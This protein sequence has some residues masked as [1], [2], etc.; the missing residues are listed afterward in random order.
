MKKTLQIVG[1]IL[2]IIGM[3]YLVLNFVIKGKVKAALDKEAHRGKLNY[4][5]L[6]Y[7]VFNNTFRVDSLNLYPRHDTIR[8]AHIAV[9]GLGYWAYLTKNTIKLGKISIDRPTIQIQKSSNAQNSGKH[10]LSKIAADK[11]LVVG[12]LKISGGTFTLMKDTLKQLQLDD[13]NVSLER[14]ETSSKTLEKKIP[15]TYQDYAIQGGALYYHASLLQTLKVDSLNLTKDE[16]VFRHLQ[17][18]PNYS[19]QDYIKVIPYEKDLMKINLQRLK[20]H[21]YQFEFEGKHPRFETSLVLLDSI[22]VNIYRN[23]LVK[24]DPREKKMYSR[25]IRELPLKL[26]I[27]SLQVIGADLSY[28]EVQEKTE[29]TGKVFFKDMDIVGTDITNIHLEREDFPVTKLNIAT[30]FYGVAPLN[31]QW[32]FKTNQLSDEFRIQGESHHI[33]AD[34]V[35]LFFE[36]GMNLKAKGE[37]IQGLYFDFEGDSETAGGKYKM[38][39]DDFNIQVLK[40]NGQKKSDFLSAIANIFVKHNNKT[41][42]EPVEVSDVKRDKTRSFWNYFWNCTFSGL[43]KTML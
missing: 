40:D 23:K 15:F 19:R 8:V 1:I 20:I 33:P 3:G 9:Q 7:D 38:V 32:Q 13:Y 37:G 42:D 28:E 29:R 30:Q 18:L 27:D 11:K 17:W 31:V 4:T 39:Y 43:K 16:A 10:S 12:E 41:N 6:H 34:A 5:A 22:D 14:V 35:N 21:D 36:P 25:M 2:L 26:K 24:D